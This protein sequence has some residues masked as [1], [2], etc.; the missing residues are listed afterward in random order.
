MVC[1]EEFDETSASH[2]CG[3]PA[4]IQAGDQGAHGAPNNG[5][6]TL[7]GVATA[8]TPHARASPTASKT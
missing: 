2:G 4:T 1:A 3:G 8:A 5:R 6:G 7:A